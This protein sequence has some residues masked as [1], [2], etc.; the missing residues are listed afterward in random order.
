ME[1][2]ANCNGKVF[3]KG[4]VCQLEIAGLFIQNKGVPDKVVRRRSKSYYFND[5]LIHYIKKYHY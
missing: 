1:G 3:Q 2:A 4:V 5:F